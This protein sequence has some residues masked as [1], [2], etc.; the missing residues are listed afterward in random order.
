M[1]PE[2]PSWYI[3]WSAAFLVKFGMNDQTGKEMISSWWEDFAPHRPTDT[4]LRA[5]MSSLLAATVRP[6]RTSDYF[7]MLLADIKRQRADEK[8]RRETAAL[9]G[10]PP[11]PANASRTAGAVR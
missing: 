5:A 9:C 11:M 2:K 7:S 4:E 6:I 10:R 1:I 8:V 3:A